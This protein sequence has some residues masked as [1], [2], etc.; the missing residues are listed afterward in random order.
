VEKKS[1]SINSYKTGSQASPMTEWAMVSHASEQQWSSKRVKD[2]PVAP[3]NIS[4]PAHSTLLYSYE[5][6]PISKE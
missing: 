2:I 1:S 4:H 3:A 5:A 6:H